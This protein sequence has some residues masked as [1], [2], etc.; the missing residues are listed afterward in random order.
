MDKIIHI[1]FV[2]ADR[3][4]E[5][6]ARGALLNVGQWR[7][8][9]HFAT[10]FAAALSTARERTPTLICFE[11][12]PDEAGWRSFARDA[13]LLSPE[14]ALV[15]CHAAGVGQPMAESEL[16]IHMLRENI[17]DIIHR[18]V[19]GPELRQVLDRLFLSGRQRVNRNATVV[20]VIS[21]K[22]GVGKSTVSVNLAAELAARHPGSVLLIDAS[23]QLG[24]CSMMLNLPT[25]PNLVDVVR[26]KER[27]DE[28]LLRELT[29]KHECG[30]HVIGGPAD[31]V[32]ASEVD[33]ISFTRVLSLARRT[34]DYVIVD[35]FPAVD[36]M[37]IAS[38]DASDL[39]YILLQ[40]TVPNTIGVARFLPV[41]DGLRV[42]RE[43]QRVVLNLNHAQVAAALAPADIERKLD[44]PIAYVLP[45][46]KGIL[47]AL[48]KG[49]PYIR[50]AFRFFGF[51]KQIVRMADE[52][53]QARAKA[54]GG[55]G[56]E[57]AVAL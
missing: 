17:R 6:E 12:G 45:Y 16:L 37:L 2:G 18:P 4:L 39:V 57:G 10:S 34:F 7:V 20:S 48:N 51:A 29:L 49:V 25:E 43:R 23:L 44:R 35:T 36:P 27:L 54:L 40:G 41:I 56:E 26:A 55:G 33:D 8:Q 11:P 28:A 21:N 22:G 42:A 46:T 13:R 32:R 50:T 14:S 19:A 47:R 31:A 15:A 30:L 52:V 9:P 38:L 3:G 1:L 5:D 24:L 53:E